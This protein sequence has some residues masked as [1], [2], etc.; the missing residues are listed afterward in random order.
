LWFLTPFLPFIPIL[1]LGL[2]KPPG[3]KGNPAAALAV[4]ILV[5]AMLG[6]AIWLVVL[7]CRQG[8]AGPNRFGD[9]A[10]ITPS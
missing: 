1:V 10:P 4:I 6:L 9:P 7:Y 2:T 5:L 3:L 8:D